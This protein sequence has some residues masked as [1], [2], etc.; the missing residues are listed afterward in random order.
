M[1]MLSMRLQLIRSYVLIVYEVKIKILPQ[2]YV[3][4][5]LCKPKELFQILFKSHKKRMPTCATTI[6]STFY[7]LLVQ[8][9]SIVSV[10]KYVF[11]FLGDRIYESMSY[12]KL[13]IF[14]KGKG[15]SE[16]SLVC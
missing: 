8:E 12:L 13:L 6:S 16:C 3:S 7:K 15:D 4:L 11:V 1:M 2:Y 10:Y 5:T 9:H 14:L